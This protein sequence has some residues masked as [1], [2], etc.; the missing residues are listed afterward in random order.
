MIINNGNFEYG[1]S[2]KTGPGK[3]ENEDRAVV[4]TVVINREPCAMAVLADGMGGYSGGAL[5]SKLAVEAFDR[6]WVKKPFAKNFSPELIENEVSRLIRSINQ[7]VIDYG[8]KRS[9]KMGTTITALLLFG[10]RYFIFNVG[11]GRVYSI[12]SSQNGLDS[13]T[14]NLERNPTIDEIEIQIDQLTDDQTWVAEQ[15]KKGRLDKEQARLH[16]RRNVLLHCLGMENQF[17]IYRHSGKY[18]SADIFLVCSDGF[19]SVFS[20]SE[21][22][23]IINFYISKDMSLQDISGEMLNVAHSRNTEDD[24]TVILLRG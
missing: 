24:A 4:K 7:Q 9:H 10:S 17:D 13:T 19:Y 18:A 11:D 2:S 20:N 6:W 21:I 22:A 12:K 15:I 8:N 3:R 14:D 16:P 5:A 23:G 1:L